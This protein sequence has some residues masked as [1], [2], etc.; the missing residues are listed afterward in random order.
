MTDQREVPVDEAADRTDPRPHAAFLARY[1]AEA[2][3]SCCLRYSVSSFFSWLLLGA[4]IGFMAPMTSAETAY[5]STWRRA[6][7]GSSGDQTP[8]A[9]I[10]RLMLG[11]SGGS[12]RSG[13]RSAPR[14]R[15]PR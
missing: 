9:I 1:R 5:T 11:P 15:S 4:R 3:A 7:A 6:L 2:S 8:G 12:A 10:R 13:P 14:T